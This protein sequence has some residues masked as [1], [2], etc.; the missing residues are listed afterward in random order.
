[1]STPSLLKPP[2]I[3]SFPPFFTRQ[4]NQETERQRKDDWVK[5]IVQWAQANQKTELIVEEQL[6]NDVNSV[7]CNADIRRSLSLEDA[8]DVLDFMASKGNGEWVGPGKTRFLI[9]YKSLAEWSQLLY[10]WVDR[11]GQMGNVFTLYELLE[12][13][14]TRGEEFHGMDRELFKKVL[15]RMEEE[16]RAKIFSATDPTKLGV[17]I[18]KL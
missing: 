14:E 10:A 11:T 2:P 18:F 3:F 8:I 12:G 9:L 15:K 7:F 17:K 6:K 1:M 16:N 5:W 13:E 4:R